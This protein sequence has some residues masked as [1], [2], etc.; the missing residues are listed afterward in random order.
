MYTNSIK[1]LS[2]CIDSLIELNVKD[3]DFNLGIDN[4][5]FKASEFD[6]NLI[7]LN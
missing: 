1:V 4:V 7:E 5:K 6:N 2:H 3:H